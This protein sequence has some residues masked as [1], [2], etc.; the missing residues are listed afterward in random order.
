[1]SSLLRLTPT[2]D[3]YVLVPHVRPGVLD[4]RLKGDPDGPF[5]KTPL[6]TLANRSTDGLA[7]FALFGPIPVPAL[8]ST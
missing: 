5:R 2:G 1:L 4:H 7:S 6:L 3:G 8:A